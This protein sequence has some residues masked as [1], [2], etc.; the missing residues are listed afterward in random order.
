MCGRFGVTGDT[1]E[2]VRR[3]GAALAKPS[4]LSYN[5]APTQTI[6][7]IV[8]TPR[9]E[10]AE[11]RWGLV[12]AWAKDVAQFRMSTFNA[13]IETIATAP[14]YRGPFKS[15]RCVIPATGFFE[16]RKNLDGSK[17]PFWIYREDTA[18][19]V[20]AGLTDTWRSRATGEEVRS[21]TIITQPPT[22]FMSSIHSRMP[23]VLDV[24]AARHWMEN[25]YTEPAALY[26]ILETTQRVP[27]TAHAV[28]RA[29][30][31]VRND[32]PSLIQAID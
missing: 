22:E 26:D 5:V 6:S 2:L 31:N 10:V 7:A 19:F 8:A 17:T 23:S 14:M 25:A 16:W 1:S 9:A 13:R 21:C 24:D 11:M 4:P 12:P 3:L 29:V 32:E 20:F 30:G 18:P 15:G 27:L 28:G